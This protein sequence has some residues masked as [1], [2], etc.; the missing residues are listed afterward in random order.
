MAIK[1]HAAPPASSQEPSPGLA[2]RAAE[3]APAT[4]NDEARTVEVVWTTGARVLRGFY[5]RFYEELSLDP[6]H[7]RMERL[8]SGRAPLLDS[9]QAFGG[10]GA[11]LGVVESARLE[12][13]RGVAVVRVVKDDPAADALWNKIR[14][15]VIKNVSV[16]YRVN[17]LEKIEGGDEKIPTYRAIDWEPFEI[18]AV[19][20]GADAQAHFRA[21]ESI[22]PEKPK[23]VP[24]VSDPTAVERERAATILHLVQRHSLGSELAAQL[25]HNATPLDEARAIVL[26]RVAARDEEI[27]TDQHI[28]VLDT[29]YRGAEDADRRIE[30]MAEALASR[31]GGP[32]PSEE[33]R[34]YVRLRVPD[35]AKHLLEARGVSTRL[36]SASQIVTRAGYHTTSDFPILLQATGNRILRQA[37]GSYQGGVKRICRESSAPDFRAKTK[38]QLGEAPELEQ[39]NEA[40]EFK[41][42][43][44]AES[45]EA[46]SLGTFGKIFGLSRHALVNDDLGAFAD[47]TSRFG[48]AAA[49]FVAKKLAT[50]LASNP[51]LSDGVATFD[52]LHGNLGTAGAL[53]IITLTEALRMMRLQKGL[54]GK[55]PIDA[56]PKFLVVPAALEVVALQQLAAITATKVA[57]VNPFASGLELVVDPRLDAFS[58]KTWYLAADPSQIDGIEYA[59]LD[60]EPGPQFDSQAG[61]RVDGVEM[62]VRLDFGA[63]VVEHRS[64]FK[65]AGQ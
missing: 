5:E 10:V 1:T 65:N 57:D 40:G 16:G 54:D 32:V 37:Y 2:T 48:R 28:S 34:Q 21:E 4:L 63:G 30:L 33:A 41:S 11:V 56:T 35:M 17:R 18:S 24:A 51:V 19:P 58:D 46:Y 25:I 7:V 60:G 3:L 53:S 9:H 50:L 26:D 47:I 62:K 43:S 44:M 52:A 59:Y 14:Q 42:G 27:R 61:F 20:V 23:T 15:G 22:M 12:K 55:T 64:L 38:L 39:V 13:T 45:K 31:F 29:G 8:Q 49:E 36:L 6:K